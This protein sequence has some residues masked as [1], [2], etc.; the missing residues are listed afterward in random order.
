MQNLLRMASAPVLAQLL[1]T[2]SNFAVLGATPN[3]TN[4]GPTVI[5]GNVGVY[6]ALSITGFPP[7]TI[8]PGTGFLHFGDTVAQ[9]AQRNASRLCGLWM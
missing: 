9:Q 5:T 8:V 6:P 3:V 4:T 7:G 2:A 1:G